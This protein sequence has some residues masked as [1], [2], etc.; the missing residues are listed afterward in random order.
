MPSNSASIINSEGAIFVSTFTRA[1]ELDECLSHLVTARGNL[2]IP[3]IVI[4]QI[5][6]TEVSSVIHKWRSQIQILIQTVNAGESPLQNI[7]MN[8]LLGRE[9]AFTWLGA[10]WCIGVEDD[11]MIS[12][13][14]INFCLFAF[15]KHRNDPFFRGVNLGSKKPFNLENNN[16]YSKVSFGI[17]G[18]A[19]L[20]TKRTWKKFNPEK[21]RKQSDIEGQDAMMEH[22]VKTGYMC[23]PS[24]SRY[25]DKGWNGTH[26]SK[27]PNNNHYLDIRD[28]FVGEEIV[29]FSIYEEVPYDSFWREDSV[30][31]SIKSIPTIIARNKYNRARYILRK[32]F[33]KRSKS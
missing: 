26:A 10:E 25:L 20:I 9:I 21:L 3:L 16:K 28:S 6:S 11:V 32:A 24:N 15:R 5:G 1:T 17:H 23:T 22:Y 13:D 27:D 33:S 31:F 4:H 2:N 7:N 30:Q 29:E 8:G 12:K 14:A 18:Q 19:S